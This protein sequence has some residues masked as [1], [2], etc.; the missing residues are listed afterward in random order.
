MAPG[1]EPR[2]V[3]MIASEVAPFAKTGGLGDVLGA[4]PAALARLGW[5]VTVA[6]PR[7]RGVA[8]GALIEHFPVS[9][10]GYTREVGFFD[11]PLADGAHAL[12]V[13]CPELY[14]RESL[15]GVDDAGYPDNPRRFAV[16]VR[17]ALEFLARSGAGSSV[18]HAHD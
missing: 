15:Y 12:L 7:Y 10:G 8:A 17:A 6:L 2:R 3:F 16:L 4:L 5:D 11:A 18:V 9:V 1:S 13:D 14:D